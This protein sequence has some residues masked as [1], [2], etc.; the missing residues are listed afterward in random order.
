MVMFFIDCLG[1]EKKM[2]QTKVYMISAELLVE[3][4]LEESNEDCFIIE[5]N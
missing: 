4:I 2:Q 5:E 3:E 1:L